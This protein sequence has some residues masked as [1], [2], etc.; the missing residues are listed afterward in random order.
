[1]QLNSERKFAVTVNTETKERENGNHGG[2][3][4]NPSRSI[5]K[6]GRFGEEKIDF[7]KNKCIKRRR[8]KKH[9]H[10]K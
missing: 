7:G 9:T 1:M 10:K 5:P 6:N 3:L 8:G 4:R 2:S